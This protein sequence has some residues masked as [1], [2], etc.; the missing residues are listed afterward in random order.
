MH[1]ARLYYM[2]YISHDWSE[3]SL[4]TILEHIRDAMA[5]GYS[6]LIIHD[7][8][9]P[10]KNVPLFMA[11]QDLNM[12]CLGGGEERTEARFRKCTEAAG[13]TVSGIWDPKDGLSEGVIECS[14]AL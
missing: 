6:R 14:V 2:R 4:R 13:L 1:G 11:I 10:E 12:M 9:V 5:P 7:W 3:T 8:I